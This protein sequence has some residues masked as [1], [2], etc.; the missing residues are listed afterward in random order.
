MTKRDASRAEAVAWC[1]EKRCDFREPVF[2]PPE[3]WMWATSGDGL[4]LTPVFTNT[5]DGDVTRLDVAR[6]GEV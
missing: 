5:S 1:A 6:G 3:G 2:P 4:V